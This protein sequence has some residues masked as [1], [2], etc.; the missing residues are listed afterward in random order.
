MYPR[1]HVALFV[2]RVYIA[3]PRDR[4]KDI[5]VMQNFW[6]ERILLHEALGMFLSPF[7]P[8]LQSAVK[9]IVAVD[10]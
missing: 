8:S 10:V 7:I 5:F 4:L 6:N 1:E 2:T 3:Y 9:I